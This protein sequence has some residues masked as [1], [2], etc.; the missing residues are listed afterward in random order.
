MVGRLKIL[1]QILRVALGEASRGLLAGSA[2]VGGRASG[3][4]DAR[5]IRHATLRFRHTHH[6]FGDARVLH[7]GK[8]LRIRDI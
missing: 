7:A 6:P 1:T 5:E 3:R 4:S 8:A 2:E